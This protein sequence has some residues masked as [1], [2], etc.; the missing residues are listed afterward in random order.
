MDIHYM[1]DDTFMR[2]CTLYG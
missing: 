1:L 2:S